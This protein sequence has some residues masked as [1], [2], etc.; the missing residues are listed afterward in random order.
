[1]SYDYFKFWPGLRVI[2]IMQNNMEFAKI[3]SPDCKEQTRIS[4]SKEIIWQNVAALQCL[5][6]SS[7]CY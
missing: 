2:F 6:F 3:L 5:L 4:T 1:M 7:A